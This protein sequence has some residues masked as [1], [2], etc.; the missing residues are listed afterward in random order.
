MHQAAERL[1]DGVIDH[2]RL[3]IRARRAEPGAR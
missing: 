2:V 1:P 3:D